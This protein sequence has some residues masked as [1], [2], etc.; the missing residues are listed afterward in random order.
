MAIENPYAGQG[1]ETVH[2]SLA[3]R[4][5]GVL[6]GG[7]KKVG[8]GGLWLG[9]KTANAGWWLTQ[10]IGEGGYHLAAGTGTLAG[11]IAINTPGVI[12]NMVAPKYEKTEGLTGTKKMGAEFR[13]AA[14]RFGDVKIPA[15]AAYNFLSSLIDYQPGGEAWNETKG[16]LEKRM[17]N[18]RLT[19]R[20]K[21]LAI[22]AGL[23]ASAIR[24]SNEQ[25]KRTMG[26]VDSSVT[27]ATP[28]YSP[29]EYNVN[30]DSG[31]ATGD[32]VFALW[33]NRH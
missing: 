27:T 25:E 19:G 5:G 12:K 6:W 8:K 14:R 10:K 2:D 17:P 4:A 28:D 33:A 31:G 26:K 9:K 30:L 3:S 16:V 7:A 32:L 11:K 15:K 23:A 18:L 1:I 13:N 21:I 24:G 22:G 29:K 20:G